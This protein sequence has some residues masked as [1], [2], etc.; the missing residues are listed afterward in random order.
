MMAPESVRTR[1]GALG[2]AA[3]G[4]LLGLVALFAYAPIFAIDF[5]W[6]LKLGQI[7]AETRAIPRTDLFSAVH[8]ERPY[9]QLQWLWELLAYVTHQAAGLRGVRAMQVA[10]MVLSFVLLGAVSLR[11]LKSRAYAFFFCSLALVLF[12]DRFQARPSATLLGFVACMLPLWLSEPRASLRRTALFTFL[13]SCL[14]S[15]LHGGES[16]LAL[17]SMGALALGS[18]VEQ[19]VAADST[20]HRSREWLI[21]FAATS[22]GVLASPTLIP[23]MRDWG[24]AIGPQLATGNKEWRPSYTM[25]ENGFTPSFVLIALVPTL[26]LI[27][28]LL[29]QWRL[30]R[31]RAGSVPPFSEW[32]LC[33]GMLALSQQAVRN[34]FLCLVPLAFMLRRRS[35]ALDSV[36]VRRLLAACSL[37]LLLAAFHDHVV[38]GYGGVHEAAELIREDL[39][40]NTFPVELAEFMRDA[41]IEGGALNDGRWAG[42]LIWRLWPKVLM[43]VD[44]RHDLT[45]EMW[46][47]FLAAQ[48]PGTRPAAME[49]A[50]RRWGIELAT[51][52]GPTFPLVRPP[53]NWR[54]LYKA[55]DQ[56]LYQHVG[57]RHAE[58]NVARA[59]TWLTA[60]AQKPAEDLSA[61]ATQ[62]GGEHW[63]RAPYQ[64]YRGHEAQRLLA[65]QRLE[66]V[67][68]GLA[69]QAALLFDAGRHAQALATLKL[70]LARQPANTRAAYQALLAS[71]ALGDHVEA[72]Q[73]FAVLQE[74]RAE[75]SPPQRNRL[76][77]IEKADFL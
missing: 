77:A 3:A 40:P 28:Y 74:R 30:R 1:L 62:V 57:G 59:M 47:V 48:M 38:E 72:R 27:A 35:P 43:F 68:R 31:E 50:F 16:L 71:L 33:A 5:F 54:L 10:C 52:R 6:H 67:T 34:A 9:V 17:L 11:A 26:V 61:L 37:C 13:V 23:G 45:P 70:L 64:V 8:P 44:S 65:S 41:G 29:E 53:P 63:L 12:E 51:F 22:F 7:I 60:R 73:W 25:L 15:N 56:E 66:D 49:Q 4:L 46:P 55:G 18:Y 69:L 2:I 20:P 32:L 39:A 21:L 58:T 24:W 14:W 36:R 42:Y 76:L 19:R 75:L